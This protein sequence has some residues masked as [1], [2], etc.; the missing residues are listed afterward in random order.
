MSRY[1]TYRSKRVSSPAEEIQEWFSAQCM[2]ILDDFDFS[3]T[4]YSPSSSSSSSSRS[5]TYYRD[6]TRRPLSISRPR[7]LS[8]AHSVQHPYPNNQLDRRQSTIRPLSLNRRLSVILPSTPSKNKETSRHESR[9]SRV[10]ISGLM[11]EC[12]S[13]FH[14]LQ[15]A[16]G[17]QCVEVHEGDYQHCADQERNEEDGA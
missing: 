7:S 14:E 12:D 3:F 6:P 4:P 9:K 15:D 16:D 8:R 10:I 11:E 5:A 2:E 17:G 13:L 1:S